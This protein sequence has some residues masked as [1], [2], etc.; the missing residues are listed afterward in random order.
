MEPEDVLAVAILEMRYVRE[1]L[2][3]WKKSNRVNV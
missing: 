2:S 1:V 3:V